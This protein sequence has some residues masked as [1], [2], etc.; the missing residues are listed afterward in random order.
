ML[1]DLIRLSRPKHWI[2]NVFVFLPVPF[3]LASGAELDP[4]RFLSGLFAVCLAASAVYAVNDA[5]DAARDRMHDEKKN[6]P[7]AAGRITKNVAYLWATALFGIG[8]TLAVATRSPAALT[9]Y[10]LYVVMN[11]GYSFGAKHVVLLDV[12]L[13]SA[14]YVL[15]VLLGCALMGVE[16]SE[17]LLLCSGALALFIA[18][19]KRRADV[20]KG[21]GSETRPALSGYN[22]SF[23]DQAIGIS[24]C[25]TIIAYAL[26]SKE[27]TVL[28]PSRKLAALPF[29]VFGVLDYLRGVHVNRGGGSPVDAVLRSPTLIFAGLGWLGATLLSLRW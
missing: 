4:L 12:F 11:L 20:V 26:Y 14:M 16:A 5:Q 21:M 27:A 8:A 7:I 13:L 9:V 15:R 23:L 29:V 24:A 10:V 2:K 17:W 6:R 22:E 3:A 19:A 25:M 18:L 1:L 28:E